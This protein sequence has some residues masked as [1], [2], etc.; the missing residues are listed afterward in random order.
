MV[1]TAG[2]GFRGGRLPKRRLFLD[3]RQAVTSQWGYL[4]W[5]NTLLVYSS[6]QIQRRR[7]LPEYFLVVAGF[8][9]VPGG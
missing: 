3:R 5:S 6:L 1:H 2:A 4:H 9:P 7:R 8:G